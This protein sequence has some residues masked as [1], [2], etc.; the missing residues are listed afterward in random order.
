MSFFCRS[1]IQRLRRDYSSNFKLVTGEKV[2]RSRCELKITAAY[3]K[4][5]V[6]KPRRHLSSSKGKSNDETLSALVHDLSIITNTKQSKEISHLLSPSTREEL[7]QLRKK[8]LSE[9]DKKSTSTRV[10]SSHLEGNI[11]EPSA[12]DLRLHAMTQA[13][14]FVGF[15]IMDN[16]IL[17]WAG[18]QIDTHLGVLFGISTLCA[19]AIGNIISDVAGV[20]LGT[21]IEDICAKRLN[22]PTPN[23]TE[24]QRKL[25]SVRFAGQ[26]GNAIGLTVGCIIGMFPL[27]FIDTENVQRMK[28]VWRFFYCSFHHNC[29][30][31]GCKFV[32]CTYLLRY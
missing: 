27:L 1:T 30:L 18:D 24:V 8:I 19:A 6:L 20:G 5:K 23:F 14:P 17:I 16:A 12:L 31:N 11:P 13:V 2:S 28:Q 25:R 10:L 15:G 4:L 7:T 26:I 32:A 3:S 29:S 9:S 22:M 21:V